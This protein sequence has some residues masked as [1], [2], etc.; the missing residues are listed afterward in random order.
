MGGGGGGGG[1]GEE[2]LSVFHKSEMC[3]KVLQPEF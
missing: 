3:E 1:G 2:S